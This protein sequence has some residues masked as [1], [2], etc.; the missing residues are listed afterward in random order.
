[1]GSARGGR[2]SSSPDPAAARGIGV[3]APSKASLLPGA[4]KSA[5]GCGTVSALSSTGLIDVTVQS[6]VLTELVL[7]LDVL[8]VPRIKLV[9]QSGDAPAGGRDRRGL[10]RRPVMPDVDGVLTGR[11]VADGKTPVGAG[12]REVRRVHR[13]D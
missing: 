13:D 12:L 7:V 1:G 3:V 5:A 8:V 4:A 10:L 11:D 9:F 2:S 6:V